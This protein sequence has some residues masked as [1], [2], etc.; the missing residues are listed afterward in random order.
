MQDYKRR[1]RLDSFRFI[2]IV[3]NM[4]IFMMRLFF[5]FFIL[6]GRMSIARQRSTQHDDG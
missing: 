5:S 2:F 1:T 6:T 3:M 4:I